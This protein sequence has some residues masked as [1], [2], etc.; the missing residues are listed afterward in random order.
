[1]PI[2]GSAQIHSTAIVDPLAEVGDGVVVGP[3]AI[4]EG[5]VQIGAGSVI[6]ARATLI[7]PL[8]LGRGNDVG[9]NVII[10]ERPQHLTFD[11]SKATRTEI[12]DDNFFRE[13]VTVHRGSDATGVTRIG[14][15]N[16]LMANSHVGHDCRVGDHVIMANGAL[17]AGHCEL[18]DRVFVS[19]NAAIHQF[20]R[21]GRLSF[22]SGNSSST[23]DVLPFMIMTER[24]RV[25]GI[26]K[27]GMR[28]AGMPPDDIQ[29]VKQAF[30][31]LF[32][33]HAIQ[34]LAVIQLEQELGRHPI[35]SEI[36]Q[37]IRTSKRGFIS[38]H[39][40]DTGDEREA[41]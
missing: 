22:L 38:A 36:L 35:G 30:R 28:R 17:L 13:G 27:V 2:A 1:M 19:G 25:A 29:V 23:K 18:H 4:V 3:F 31:I 26:N 37:F 7:G 9:I 15:H 6:R 33:T 5:Q 20:A 12:G 16:Y 40:G 10:G 34:K 11:V 41:A 32:R 8:T 24:D 39:H 21:L 14:S